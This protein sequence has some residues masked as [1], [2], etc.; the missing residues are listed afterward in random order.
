MII[1]PFFVSISAKSVH[2]N[3]KRLDEMQSSD[4]LPSLASHSLMIHALVNLALFALQASL[5]AAAH[6]QVVIDI[7]IVTDI[8]FV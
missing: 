7:V 6:V 1:V 2:V 4:F 3:A 8:F 5:T